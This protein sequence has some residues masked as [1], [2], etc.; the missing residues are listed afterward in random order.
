MADNASQWIPQGTSR[1]STLVIGGDPHSLKKNRAA[2]TQ[3]V[4]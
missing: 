1:P 2:D 4:R 3:K